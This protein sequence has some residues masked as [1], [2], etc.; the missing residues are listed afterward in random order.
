MCTSPL[1]APG[2]MAL[3]L[4][5]LVAAYLI[6]FADFSGSEGAARRWRVSNKLHVK[7]D[8]IVYLP[9]IKASSSCCCV[10]TSNSFLA[11]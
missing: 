1:R 2:I 6:V 3:S 10:C 5:F 11:G 7:P 9:E 4:F 8:G